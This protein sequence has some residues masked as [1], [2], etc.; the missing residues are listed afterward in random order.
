MAEAAAPDRWSA[1]VLC[2]GASRRM[3]RDKA[4]LEV[5][6]RPMVAR[7]VAAAR[8]A[9]AAEVIT[10]GGD[11]PGIRAA[12]AGLGGP[13]ARHVPDRHPGEGPLGGLLTALAALAGA[14]ADAAL[15]V[16]CDLLAPDAG[17]MAA[18]VAALARPVDPLATGDARPAVAD[19]VA[20]TA[21]GSPG[22]ER[23]ATP[24]VAV[25][26]AAGRRQWL[27]AAWRHDP[28]VIARL[29]QRFGAG[30]RSIRRAVAQAGLTVVAVPD[31]DPAALADADT[32][33]DLRQGT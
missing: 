27:H 12:L 16:S 1:A 31:A 8:A 33:D 5:A 20:L 25:P 23:A 3:G 21:G 7:V 18:T 14:G 11:E 24:D 15:I 13:T 19:D 4:L 29:D 2:G 9:G 30:E 32:P 22:V 26:E 28:D 10:V 6:G 17:T